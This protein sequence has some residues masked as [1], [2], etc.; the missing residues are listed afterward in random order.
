MTD[1][2]ILRM[3]EDTTKEAS[4]HQLETLRSILER[5][6]GVLYLRSHLQGHDEQPVDAATFRRAVPLSSYDDYVDH[7]DR[8][9]DGLVDHDLPLLSVD[10][11]LCFFYSSGTSA[12]KPKLIPYFDS[13]LSKAAS[14]M[15]H[16][17][18][19]SILRRSFPPRT[20]VSKILW[21]I[22]ADNIATTKGGFKVMAASTYPI[23]S[24]ATN[25]SQFLSCSSPRE[26]I[27]GSNVE[28]QM[29]CHL[30]CGLRNS[31][32]IDGIRVPYAIGLIKVFGLLES[33]WKQLCDDLECGVPSLE[34]SDVAM[35]DSVIEVLGGPQ[36]ELSR[37][38]WAIC[39]DKNWGGIVS[40]LWPNV[41]FIR[42]VTTGSL[43]QYYPKLKQ[44]A[45]EVPVLGGDYFA[46]ECCV[47]INMDITQPPERTRFILLPTA[48]YFEFLP[49]ASDVTD[50]VSEETVDISGV[51]AGK[52][53]EVV[54]TTYRGFYRYHLG[55]IVRVVGF[56][57]S[58]PLVEFVM[59][60]PRA[61]SEVVTEKDLLL[62]IEYFQSVLRS[63]MAVE[64]TEFSS[65]LDLTLGP[66]LLKVYI[67]VREECMFLPKEKIEEL[68]V[69]LKEC[70]S[71][72]GD[73]LGDKYNVQRKRGEID[74]LV[75][76]IVKPG[77]FDALSQLAIEN[78]APA[79]Q[80]KP[81]KIIRN[82]QIVDFIEKRILVTV[83]LDG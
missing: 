59:R 25:W 45:G 72:I 70:G 10:T 1:E 65:F 15:A 77:S 14:F 58:S 80:Y 60:A 53:Y 9:A 44:Y 47:G 41:R 66:K 34:I 73:S 62:A 39:E 61:P 40:K 82:H 69:I 49:F 63:A 71:S 56:Y 64:I 48:A 16:Q 79:T 12:M 38:I 30:L 32:F 50:V 21:F 83:S 46:S 37:R 6:A 5:Q 52:M 42:C 28:H 35:R 4:R 2:E 17:G 19:A 76:S 27:L 54:V 36:P 68:V 81:P 55:D 33:K 57:N 18:S 8:M 3:L 43:A 26:V 29:Y 7:I 74:P 22:Y 67:E 20:S 78:G 31:D 11:L 51:E 13:K 75:V 24:G 23:H